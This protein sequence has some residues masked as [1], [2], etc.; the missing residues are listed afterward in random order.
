MAGIG[1]TINVSGTEHVVG[2]LVGSVAKS[3]THGVGEDGD[4]CLL[5]GVGWVALLPHT[6]PSRHHSKFAHVISVCPR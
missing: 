1:A 6:T 3:A 5:Q 2:N 4:E